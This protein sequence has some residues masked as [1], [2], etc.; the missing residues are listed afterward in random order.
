MVIRVGNQTERKKL[1][2][3]RDLNQRDEG[4]RVQEL[5]PHALV[6]RP[7]LNGY[8]FVCQQGKRI[9]GRLWLPQYAGLSIYP[10]II[11]HKA[12]S[13]WKAPFIGHPMTIFEKQVG[14]FKEHEKSRIIQDR[15]IREFT[16]R[17]GGISTFWLAGFVPVVYVTDHRKS[18]EMARDH[19]SRIPLNESLSGVSE[20][21]VEFL[22]DTKTRNFALG[23]LLSHANLLKTVHSGC[24]AAKSFLTEV[25]ITNL[26]SFIHAYIEYVE[27]IALF[28][29]K[30]VPL[31]AY[32]QN[33]E[34]KCVLHEFLETIIDITLSQRQQSALARKYEQAMAKMM[35]DNFQFIQG[36]E[37]N[38]FK[39]VYETGGVEFPQTKE[40]IGK[41]GEPERRVLKQCLGIIAGASVNTSNALNWVIRHIETNPSIKER[42]IQE[43]QLASLDFGSYKVI[44]ESLPYTLTIV[45]ESLRFTPI[46]AGLGKVVRQAHAV[47]IGAYDVPLDVNTFILIDIWKS[48]RTNPHFKD[49]DSFNP[50]NIDI[51]DGITAYVNKNSLRTFGGGH[52]DKSTSK[53]PGRLFSVTLQAILIA[54]LYKHFEVQTEN[55]SLNA[56][57]KSAYQFHLLPEDKGTV[58]IK[59]FK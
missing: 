48:N 5:R 56:E 23:H 54:Y 34:S 27:S 45:L 41:G 30:K 36:N 39:K 12:A 42:V 3:E 7:W 46:V 38:I 43:A 22:L 21:S 33:A 32:T 6:R 19:F 11:S 58:S 15:S 16:E 9:F 13:G 47:K 29:F 2:A 8:Q 24:E 35:S 59:P 52:N 51:K 1:E 14:I 25:P 50:E 31:S 53:C 10:G 28:D 37:G 40:A 18:M 26:S 20:V 44:E 17:N 55:V 4:Q 57:N 49:P